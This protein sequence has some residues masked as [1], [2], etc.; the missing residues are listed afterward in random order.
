MVVTISQ[1]KDDHRISPTTWQQSTCRKAE[2][3]KEIK[4]RAG[5]SQSNSHHCFAMKRLSPVSHRGSATDDVAV[6]VAPSWIQTWTKKWHVA[7][8]RKKFITHRNSACV[9]LSSEISR[10]VFYLPRCPM[11][12]PTDWSRLEWVRVR[13]RVCHLVSARLVFVPPYNLIGKHTIWER[14]IGYR[15]ECFD[16]MSI[17]R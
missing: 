17:T 8:H 12:S 13:G 15:R 11:R 7:E 5:Q 14:A 1:W 6:K 2:R 16:T 10:S 4:G 3:D 9:V